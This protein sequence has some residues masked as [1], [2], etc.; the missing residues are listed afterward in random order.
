MTSLLKAL[1]VED[2]EAFLRFICSTLQETSQFQVMEAFDGLEAVQMAEETQPDLV[3]LDIGLPELSG[4]EAGRRIRRLAPHA[5]L[6]FVSSESAPDVV[7]ETF[8]L[9]GRAYVDK[10]RCDCDLLPAIEA[11][12]SGKRFVSHSLEFK[13]GADRLSRHEVLF[14]SDDSVFLERSARFI[15]YALNDGNAAIVL[16]TEPHREGLVERLRRDDIGIEDAIQRRIYISL[17]AV[18]TLTTAMRNGTPDQA[19]FVDGVTGLVDSAA[20]A[21]KKAQ[22]RVVVL[23]E[24]VSLL[25]SEGKQDAAISLEKCAN[26]VIQRQ[27]LDILCPYSWS[28]IDKDDPAVERICAEH[29]GVDLL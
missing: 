21:T 22:P 5:K 17:D 16:A 27:D 18:E 2:N 14:Y 7:R 8:R 1:V 6:L 24:C 4:I 29:S 19:R 20:R 15:A 3:L 26:D 9:G 11:A 25:C 12:L 28:H 23:D 10:A 13:V